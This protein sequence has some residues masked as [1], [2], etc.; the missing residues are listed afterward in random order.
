M[1]AT[2]VSI[3]RDALDRIIA[4][5]E[6]C[7]DESQLYVYEYDLYGRLS[8]ETTINSLGIIQLESVW[9]N[10][11][12]D[13][14][15]IVSKAQ[16]FKQFVGSPQFVTDHGVVGI[17]YSYETDAAGLTTNKVSRLANAEKTV[18]YS[19]EY[20]FKDSQ[21]D[22]VLKYDEN[23]SLRFIEKYSYSP[24]IIRKTV[25]LP[26][27]TISHIVDHHLFH[28]K[29]HSIREHNPKGGSYRWQLTDKRADNLNYIIGECV[30]PPEAINE[31]LEYSL[32]VSY[33]SPCLITI[34]QRFTD[35]EYY[36]PQIK[37]IINAFQTT[38]K[39]SVQFYE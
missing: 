25:S 16:Y 31:I 5:R 27:S 19:T 9:N 39:Y 10:T 28:N 1:V 6:S 36:Y 34:S 22:C 35:V 20:K 2:R 33:S 38:H 29:I 7:G 37:A 17:T 4:V 13:M 12:D 8:H 26:C 18:I 24:T 3:S 14:G 15:R 21:L 23:D 32:E 11:Y 30:L